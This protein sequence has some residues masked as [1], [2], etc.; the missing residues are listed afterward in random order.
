MSDLISRQLCIDALSPMAGVGNRIIDK[1]R[2]L[3]SAQRER[4]KWIPQ[5]MNKSYGMISTAVYY[6]PKCSVCGQSANYTN[7]CPNCGAKMEEE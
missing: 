2:S 5:D 4:G 3:P 1:I 7:F 6:Y